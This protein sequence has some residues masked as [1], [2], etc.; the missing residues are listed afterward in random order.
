MAIRVRE[1]RTSGDGDGASRKEAAG[2]A[3]SQPRIAHGVEG[4]HALSGQRPFWRSAGKL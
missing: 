3:G 2:L 4:E 1:V